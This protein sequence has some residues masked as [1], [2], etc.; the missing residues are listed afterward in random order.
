MIHFAYGLI[1]DYCKK[2]DLRSCIHKFIQA[3][4][5]SI[6]DHMLI[7]L[8]NGLTCLTDLLIKYP[9]EGQQ[10]VPDVIQKVLS[11]LR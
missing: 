11:I 1:S 8:S 6:D 7:S 4:A 9:A 3:V 2:Y 5:S 10:Y